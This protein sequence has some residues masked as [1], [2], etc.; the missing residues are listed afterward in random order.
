MMGKSAK[1][2]I[3][4]NQGSNIVPTC[5]DLPIGGRTGRGI[6]ITFKIPWRS[7]FRGRFRWRGS[8]IRIGNC[9]DDGE[10][11][12][13]IISWEPKLQY[14]SNLYGPLHWWKDKR[15]FKIPCKSD[16][17]L[18]FRLKGSVMTNWDFS[19]DGESRENIISREPKLQSC[20]NLYGPLYWWQDWAYKQKQFKNSIK[21]FVIGQRELLFPRGNHDGVRANRKQHF[22]RCGSE[23]HIANAPS[24]GF[25][26]EKK[27]G[28]L[29]VSM[30]C[31]NGRLTTISELTIS[32]L[33]M[34][35]TVLVS[36]LAIALVD[37][38]P[39]VAPEPDPVRLYRGEGGIGR[40]SYSCGGRTIPPNN[41]NNEDNNN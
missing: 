29:P 9:W 31:A 28:D 27:L 30:P 23:F 13:N 38:A 8:V 14:C 5:T 34:M 6:K 35:T 20:S 26:S 15:T 16:F 22:E 32:L 12:E 24:A 10:S 18:R 17:R 19:D 41:N 39:E 7:N 2:L 4:V 11:R 3:L 40:S 1:I 36:V 37:T 21:M 25:F 33:A